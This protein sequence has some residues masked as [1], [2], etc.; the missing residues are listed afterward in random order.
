M[1]ILEYIDDASLRNYVQ[2]ALNRGEAYHQLRRIVA[3]VNVNRF[4]GG[5]DSEIDLWNE[6]TRL[7]T[8]A[9]IYFNSLILSKLLGHYARQKIK[10]GQMELSG[11]RIKWG[12]MKLTLLLIAVWVYPSSLA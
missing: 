6:C 1:Y 4:R 3:S 10:W 5:S 7:L 12:Q 2:R 9:I 8:N 11:V